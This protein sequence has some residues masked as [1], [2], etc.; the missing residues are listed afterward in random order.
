M[1]SFPFLLEFKMNLTFTEQNFLDKYNKYV[2]FFKG[3]LS[4]RLGQVL[5]QL[6]EDLIGRLELI[7][8]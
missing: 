3:F 1:K 4:N 2:F 8:F 6:R 5:T 7:M